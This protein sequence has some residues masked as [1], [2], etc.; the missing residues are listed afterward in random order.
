[1]IGLRGVQTKHHVLIVA[2]L[3]PIMLHYLFFA[4]DGDALASFIVSQFSVR[5]IDATVGSAVPSSS[6]SS[7]DFC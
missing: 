4:D 1:M 2:F 7:S 6:S 5:K 3:S